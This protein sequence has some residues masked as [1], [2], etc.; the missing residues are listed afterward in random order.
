M[1]PVLRMIKNITKPHHIG[2]GIRLVDSMKEKVSPIDFANLSLALNF[3]ILKNMQIKPQNIVEY[4]D[5]RT[6]NKMVHSAWLDEDTGILHI[7]RFHFI[8]STG[9]GWTAYNEES[10]IGKITR[11]DDFIT[12]LHITNN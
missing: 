11:V 6:T 4:L 1:E 2:L 12:F 5:G 9:Y 10:E 7:G 3:Q 8:H